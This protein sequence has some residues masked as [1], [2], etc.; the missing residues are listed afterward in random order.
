MKPTHLLL[1]RHGA[2]DLQAAG[3]LAGWMPGVHLNQEGQA[4]ALA[5]ARRLTPIELAAVYTSPLE[6]ARETAEIVAAPHGLPAVVREGLGEVRFGRWTGQP[7]QQL[8]RRR[9]WR[10]AQYV[11]STARFPG[12]ES[13]REMQ[14]RVVAEIEALQAKHPGQTIAVVAHADV[15]KAGMAHFVGLHLDLFQR[16]VVSPASLTVLQLGGP[17]PRLVSLNDTGH[18][19][20]RANGKEEG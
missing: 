13:I 8:R 18:L 12:G 1:I 17:M 19:P 7:V 5:L 15:I 11:P 3:V 14:T 20:L 2:N 9:L 4:Q 16:L 10:A 6:R